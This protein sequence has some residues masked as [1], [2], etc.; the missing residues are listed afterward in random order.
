[1]NVDASELEGPTSYMV[2]MVLRNHKGHFVEGRTLKFDGV[3]SVFEAEVRGIREALSWTTTLSSKPVT[4]ENDSLIAINAIFSR[5]VNQLEVGH[6]LEEFRM[7]LDAQETNL[8]AA[9]L[10]ARVPC[11]LHCHNVLMSPPNVVLETIEFDSI[12]H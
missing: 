6:I 3:V 7:S 1:M 8:K 4:V 10:M 9:H 2:G 12:L 11:S 5:V